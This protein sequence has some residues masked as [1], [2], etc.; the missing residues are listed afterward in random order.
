MTTEFWDEPFFELLEFKF[1]FEQGWKSLK[2]I[3]VSSCGAIAKV[4]CP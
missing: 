4:K 3:E 2:E 1:L